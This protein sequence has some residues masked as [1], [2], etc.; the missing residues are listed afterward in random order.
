MVQSRGLSKE[1]LLDRILDFYQESSKM[2]PVLKMTKKQLLKEIRAIPKVQLDED[3]YNWCIAVLK[4]TKE[5]CDRIQ[6]MMNKRGALLW[7]IKQHWVMREALSI[8]SEAL[9]QWDQSWNLVEQHDLEFSNMDYAICEFLGYY[10]FSHPELVLVK[11][12][13]GELEDRV[14]TMHDEEGEFEVE[15]V[16]RAI[17]R[18][19]A[20]MK[21]MAS[22]PSYFHILENLFY[23]SSGDESTVE[24]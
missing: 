3:P 23:Y 9:L 8:Y 21:I 7:P 12:D 14:E 1:V 4:M 20:R 5:V 17:P 19:T 16:I 11:M 18:L 10:E 13:D 15:V 2:P 24:D 6:G 22:A